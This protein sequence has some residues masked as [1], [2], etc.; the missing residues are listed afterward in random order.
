MMARVSSAGRESRLFV[1]LRWSLTSQGATSGRVTSLKPPPTSSTWSARPSPSRRRP[2]ASTSSRAA[3]GESSSSTSWMRSA[4]MGASEETSRA[5]SPSTTSL[6]SPLP[7]RLP[8]VRH[9]GPRGLAHAQR[10]LL[11]GD[12][13]EGL[14]LAG[15]DLTQAHELQQ[16]QQGDDPLRPDALPA[17]HR[18]EEQRPGVAQQRQDLVHALQHRER[19]GLD[20]ARRPTLLLLD[21]A[22]QRALEQVHREVLERD[23][24]GRRQL[25]AGTAEEE[26]L[27]G[28]AQGE[29]G[30]HGLDPRVLPEPLRE[31]LPQQ[32][33]LLVERLGSVVGTGGQQELGLQVDQRGR[34]DHE[35]AGRL[36]VLEAHRFEMGQV[37]VRDGPHGEMGEVHLVGAA[38]MQQEVERPDEGLDPDGEPARLAAE[39]ADGLLAHG[40]SFT[41]A[42]TW[43]M[44]SIAV[45]RARFEP[46]WRISTISRG[47][48][49]KRR[50]RS[51]IAWSGGSMCSRR[52]ALQSRQPM[53]AVRQPV[54]HAARASSGVKMRCRSNTGQTSGLPGS[55]RRLR[56]GSVTIG[57]ILAVISSGESTR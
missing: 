28:L 49:A 51:R 8:I 12:L 42:R 23:V 50:R 24:L 9:G 13:S 25:A 14:R 29:P 26:R 4:S 53:P 55:L 35:G 40:S 46:S 44:V 21:Q 36:Q 22:L 7:I 1:L 10:V 41:A 19:V 16:G 27:L 20:L 18:G 15:A 32:L 48:S 38:E 57:L 3:A 43:S 17:G 47:R 37:L 45:R 33:A 31:L 39:G 11:D 30:T 54:A 2:S 6:M 34:H 5:S 52:T 56:A